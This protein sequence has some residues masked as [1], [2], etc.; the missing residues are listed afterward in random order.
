[1]PTKLRR[2]T[3]N[4]DPEIA[5]QVEAL[6]IADDRTVSNY[7]S[8]LIRRYLAAAAGQSTPEPMKDPSRSGTR[9][10][11]EQILSSARSRPSRAARRPAPNSP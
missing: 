7:L 2:Y 1:V 6:A 4:L 8:G 3:V 10:A 11:A 5:D 9:V